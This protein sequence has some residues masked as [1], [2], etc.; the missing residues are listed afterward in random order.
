MNLFA[1]SLKDKVKALT[2][3]GVVVKD[4]FS[5]EIGDEVPIE[6]ISGRNV[7][8][9]GG[10]RIYGSR[11]L[12]SPGVVIGREGPATIVDCYI[13]P[14]VEL[15]GGFFEGSVFLEGV[16]IASGAHVREGCLLEEE[17]KVGHTV[18]LKQTILF[19]YATLG[20]LINFCDCLLSGG[21]GR[22]NHS[23]VGSVYVHFNFTPQQD[24]ATPSL[25]GDVPR[26]VM[27]CESP[28]FLGGQGGLVGPVHIDYG[29]VISAGTVWRRDSAGRKLLHGTETTPRCLPYNPD[30]YGD[31]RNKVFNNINYIA[32]LM[33]L[34]EWY[35]HVRRPF[36]MRIELGEELFHGAL[37]VLSRSIS[38]RIKRLGELARKM[39][40]SLKA[41]QEQGDGDRDTLRRQ[42][43][44]M[45]NWPKIEGYLSSVSPETM[46]LE[47]KEAFLKRIGKMQEK[48]PDYL[49][50]VRL[51]DEETRH[52]G[53]L[54]LEDIVSQ[55][56]EG[57]MVSLKSFH[58]Q[59][60]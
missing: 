57:A 37:D 58:T 15:K 48:A 46:G 11:T 10:T 20:S 7:V 24:K 23:E 30:L 50:M 8:L 38:E 32:N 33:A 44:F 53:T 43:E 60:V 41:W 25:L 9:H 6:R 51:F 56:R 31:I 28:I 2:E 5:L 3:K 29:T 1:M 16:S 4:P 13:A 55:V 18:G 47:K 22:D 54:W 21:T 26:G 14:R 17:T 52:L 12:I 42:R 40:K 27:L 35:F 36:F 59:L 39:E 19:P 34:R 45:E 49:K